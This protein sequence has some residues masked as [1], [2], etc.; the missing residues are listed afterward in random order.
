MSDALD[1][2]YQKLEFKIETYYPEQ[3]QAERRVCAY[4]DG[5]EVAYGDTFKEV[6]E[7]LDMKI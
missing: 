3:N 2:R 4:I 7:I 5:E 1:D 6:I